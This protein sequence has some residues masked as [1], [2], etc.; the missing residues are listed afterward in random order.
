MLMR[1]K[2]AVNIGSSLG[3]VPIH[4]DQS[5]EKIIQNMS[6]FAIKI[7]GNYKHIKV[8]REFERDLFLIVMKIDK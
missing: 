7:N 6:R 3:F 4:L 8:I 1:P 2:Y 5:H